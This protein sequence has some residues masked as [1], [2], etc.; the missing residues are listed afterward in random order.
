MKTIKILCRVIEVLIAIDRSE[1][2][3]TYNTVA[4]STN[5][6]REHYQYK[7]YTTTSGQPKL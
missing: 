4:L 5:P 7:K 6:R 1:G 2:S 3:V